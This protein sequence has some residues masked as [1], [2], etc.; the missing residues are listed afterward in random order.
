MSV[1]K[2]KLIDIIEPFLSRENASSKVDQCGRISN[3]TVIEFQENNI[4]AKQIEST[5][6]YNSTEVDH[7]FVTVPA[8]EITD[9][10]EGPV[11]I[12]PTLEQF[13]NET[14]SQLS[15]RSVSD[16]D[17]V[18]IIDPSDPLYTNYNL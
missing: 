10:S 3:M 1:S 14:R 8:S 9:V 7:S 13:G 5:F 18:A 11:I 17:S 15:I 4:Q 6:E 12:D 2:E 16:I